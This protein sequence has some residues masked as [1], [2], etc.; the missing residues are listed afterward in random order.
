MFI[1]QPN[2][3]VFISFKNLD[4]NNNPTPD[5]LLAK[6]IYDY[7]LYHKLRTFFSNITLEE[8][9]TAAFMKEINE[10]LDSS[11]I[12]V[13]VGAKSENLLQPWV[14]HEY[15]SFYQDILDK[16]KP[17]GKIFV[18]VDG[19]ETKS[20]PRILRKNQTII[21]GK[22]SIEHLY[23]FVINAL[24]NQDFEKYDAM[25]SFSQTD[26]EIAYILN[27]KLKKDTKLNIFL[28]EWDFERDLPLQ[29][30]HVDLDRTKFCA[31]LIGKNTPEIWYKNQLNDALT[32]MAH[33]DKFRV[34]PVLLEGSPSIET[35]NFPE[36]RSWVDFKNGIDNIQ[37]YQKL[38][39][40]LL[41]TV[42]E[43]NIT[44]LPKDI[45]DH[46]AQLKRDLVILK[47]AKKEIEEIH[48]G[49]F[50]KATLDAIR[51]H[52]GRVYDG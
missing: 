42:P 5:S 24:Q 51:R 10:A 34:L 28:D 4:S 11:K 13:V 15:E 16:V 29:K 9:G 41:G 38:K 8:R 14:V 44:K 7:F 43:V 22:G 47:G 50:E 35:N 46:I 39:S 32:H 31:V 19:I 2:F 27:K 6:Q 25:L 52:M 36:L 12:L 26:T 49:M 40:G 18:Y 30:N 3:D 17:D 48:P 45:E 20:L 1:L 33:D 21:H 23:N 37:E